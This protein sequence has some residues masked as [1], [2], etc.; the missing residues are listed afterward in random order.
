MKIQCE[1]SYLDSAVATASRAAAVKSP[2]PALEGLLLQASKRIEPEMGLLTVTGY[3]LKKGIYAEA[4]V[5]LIE[6][7]SVVLPAKM[8]GEIV[9]KLPDGIVTISSDKNFKTHINCGK[10]DYDIM[11]S[12]PADYPALPELD[13]GARF[14]SL[15]MRQ[16]VMGAMIRQ[17]AFAISDNESRPI[18]TGELLECD[19][20]TVTMVALDGY[21]LAVRRE[22]AASVSPE[23]ISVIIPGSALSDVEKLCTDEQGSVCLVLGNKFLKFMLNNVTLITRKLEGEFLNYHKAVPAEFSISMK[24][25]RTEL[26]RCADRVSLMIDDRAKNPLRCQFGS[27]NLNITS[28]TPLGRAE[29]NCRLEGDGKDTVIGLNNSYLLQALK[30]APADTLLVK[31]NNGNSPIVFTPEEGDDSFVYMILPVRLRTDA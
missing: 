18:Y 24:G 4:A 28:A 8:F 17:T 9:R 10:A 19:G 25:E 13:A 22:K 27:G 29:D 12:D 20:E 23:P 16:T 14:D 6:S 5:D 2:I 31:L 30:A 11:G 26:I 21:R 1:K 3:D 15:V 7:G